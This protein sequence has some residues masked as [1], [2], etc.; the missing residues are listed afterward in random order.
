[1]G[2]GDEIMATGIAKIEKIKFPHKQIVI[3]NFKQ[4]IV[5]QSIVFLNN[6]NIIMDPKKIDKNKSI[7]FVNNYPGNR[8]H[9]DYSK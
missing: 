5:T 9:I 3:G 2:Y 6:P 1:M 7:H 4:K 8:P